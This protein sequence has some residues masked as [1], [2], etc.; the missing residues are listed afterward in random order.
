M[1]QFIV[2][3]WAINQYEQVGKTAPRKKKEIKIQKSPKT[4]ILQVLIH[5][6]IYI[7]NFKHEK[8]Y[9]NIKKSF[10]NKSNQSG[11]KNVYWTL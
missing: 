11:N 4:Q 3:W 6:F 9:V 10:R 5:L 8:F 2:F 1:L 7:A